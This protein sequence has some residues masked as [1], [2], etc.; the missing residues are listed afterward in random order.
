MHYFVDGYNVV[1]CSD[2]FSAGTVR[3]RR[4]KLLRF[5]EEKKP[6]GSARNRVTVVFDGRPG[7]A[8]FFPHGAVQVVFSCGHDA[9][10]VLKD[11]VDALSNPREAVMVTNDKAIQRWVRARGV[12]VMSCAQ[13]LSAGMTGGSRR[14]SRTLDSESVR[15]INE[16]LRKIWKLK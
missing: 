10:K 8:A 2:L 6:Q 12:H 16:E 4:E 11:R 7:A 5:I 15:S 9:D 3:V 1:Y 13:F 14:I